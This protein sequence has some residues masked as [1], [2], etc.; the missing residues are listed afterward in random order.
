ME[1]DLAPLASHGQSEVIVGV[2]CEPSSGQAHI[3]RP[4]YAGPYMQPSS[5]QA[6]ISAQECA[7]DAA[8]AEIE[9]WRCM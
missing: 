7:L 9:V 2:L 6:H 8:V 4:I 1:G 5:G 3:C